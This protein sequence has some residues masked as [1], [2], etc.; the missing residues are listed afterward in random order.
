MKPAKSITR[1]LTH[2]AVRD[3]RRNA[4]ALP[5]QDQP[6]LADRYR[7]EQLQKELTELAAY[8]TASRHRDGQTAIDSDA[9][10][11]PENEEA[12]DAAADLEADGQRVRT[13]QRGV[14][15]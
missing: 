14:D 5:P 2:P 7:D 1:G 3:Q 13:R 8:T 10:A 9:D 6:A 4:T 15:A 11:V 12:L